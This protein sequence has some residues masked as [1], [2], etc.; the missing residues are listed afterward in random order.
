MDRADFLASYDIDASN[1]RITYTCYVCA[2]TM[3][4]SSA[5]RHVRSMRHI[6]NCNKGICK[7][8]LYK[9]IILNNI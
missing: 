7:V 2:H 1:G 3:A 4:L 6:K 9:F 8:D 5:A